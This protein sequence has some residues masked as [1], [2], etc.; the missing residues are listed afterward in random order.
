MRFIRKGGH[1]SR[2]V[3]SSTWA[4]SAS[5]RNWDVSWSSSLSLPSWLSFSFLNS[6]FCIQLQIFLWHGTRIVTAVGNDSVFLSVLKD[7]V[8]V[9]LHSCHSPGPGEGVLE[10]ALHIRVRRDWGESLL[11]ERASHGILL[12]Q[13]RLHGCISFTY[14]NSNWFGIPNTGPLTYNR[15]CNAT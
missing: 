8:F 13:W 14:F 4:L 12:L 1:N 7:T 2:K 15:S 9:V 11:Q 6:D 10:N 3:T 5:R